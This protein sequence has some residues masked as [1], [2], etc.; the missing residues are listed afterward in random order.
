MD[1]AQVDA[2]NNHQVKPAADRQRPSLGLQSVIRR[3]EGEY[4][5]RFDIRVESSPDR[6]SR[7]LLL[8]SLDRPFPN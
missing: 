8:L 6:G 2:L 7:V 5:D 4:R 1:A 3:L